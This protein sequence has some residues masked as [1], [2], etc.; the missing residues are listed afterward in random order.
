[1]VMDSLGLMI[2]AW[3]VGIYRTCLLYDVH[4]RNNLFGDSRVTTA[5]AQNYIKNCLLSLSFSSTSTVFCFR[6]PTHV[7][8]PQSIQTAEKLEV[9]QINQ[10]KRFE[11]WS[12]SG[13]FLV[14]LKLVKGGNLWF[15]GCRPRH[16]GNADS[17]LWRCDCCRVKLKFIRCW[18]M[19]FRQPQTDVTFNLT[20]S[21]WFSVYPL[22]FGTVS[23]KRW[24]GGL[25]LAILF[26]CVATL[27][28]IDY[29]ECWK[30][31][32]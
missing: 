29:S 12:I 14:L 11:F 19:F 7:L 30:L 15:F 31:P 10:I 16:R 9:I 18:S 13:W 3:M 28:P 5:C 6:T 2:F 24:P 4:D 17:M 8:Q 27:K 20:V 1:M 21:Q 22:C 23:I 26:G 25:T 32:S